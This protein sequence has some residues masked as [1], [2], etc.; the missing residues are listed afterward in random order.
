MPARI[1]NQRLNS[2]GEQCDGRVNGKPKVK[3]KKK[4]Q[5]QQQRRQ[6]KS[7]PLEYVL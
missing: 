2:G 7:Q 5:K 3:R 4:R 6:K 1:P